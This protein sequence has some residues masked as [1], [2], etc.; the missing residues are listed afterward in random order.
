MTPDLAGTYKLLEFRG[1]ADGGPW[2]DFLLGP[3]PRGFAMLSAL[4]I[5]AAPMPAIPTMTAAATAR[6]LQRTTGPVWAQRWRIAG[7]TSLPPLLAGAG[8]AAICRGKS[9]VV[10]SGANCA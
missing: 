7:A 2:K 9:M 10:M 8:S 6:T 3:K 5:E 1:S 4:Y